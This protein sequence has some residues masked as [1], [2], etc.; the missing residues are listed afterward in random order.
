MGIVLTRALQSLPVNL[1]HVTQFALLSCQPLFQRIR[2]I[3][4]SWPASTWR[5]QT[6]GSLLGDAL[7]DLSAISKV[8]DF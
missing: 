4:E 5:A 6:A 2:P 3:A 7:G 8:A 1:A